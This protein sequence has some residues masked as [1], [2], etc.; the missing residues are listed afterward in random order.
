M[1]WGL[2]FRIR[3]LKFEVWGLVLGLGEIPNPIP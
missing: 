2:G 1:I 3:G